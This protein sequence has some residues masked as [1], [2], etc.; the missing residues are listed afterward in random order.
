MNQT[1]INW[2]HTW[3]P[4]YLCWIA[5]T[6]GC[7][8]L[9]AN[10]DSTYIKKWSPNWY[11]AILHRRSKGVKERRSNNWTLNIL[12]KRRTNKNN[13]MEALLPASL[14]VEMWQPLLELWEELLQSHMHKVHVVL[15]NHL[16]IS[17]QRIKRKKIEVAYINCRNFT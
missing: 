15:I 8:V 6:C 5:L 16:S 3:S 2:S 7:S 4:A 10:A 11:W 14:T 17:E 1:G 13:I 12:E 9:M